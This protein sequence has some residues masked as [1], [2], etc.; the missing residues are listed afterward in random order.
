MNCTRTVRHQ[1]SGST[2]LEIL[3]TIVILSFGLL[4][5]AGLQMVGLKN[6]KSA[7]YRSQASIMAY[8][9]ID[10]M[11][12]NRKQTQDGGY[13]TGSTYISWSGGAISGAS[14]TGMANKD[15]A[16]WIET[17]STRLPS[18][19]A[20]IEAASKATTIRITIE[21]NDSR[22]VGGGEA[23]SFSVETQGCGNNST[24]IL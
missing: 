24:C 23:Q 16:D 15:V 22:G 13:N 17:V 21:W 4:G 6:N 12:V 1:Q 5:V 7:L 11:R 3:V 14:F 10:R 2:L 9:M 18:G 20:R 8:D 19:K